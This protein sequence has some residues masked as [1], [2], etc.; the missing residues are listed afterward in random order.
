MKALIISDS[1]Y[2]TEEYLKLKTAI[3]S[4][5]EKKDFEMKEIKVREKDITYCTGCFGCWIKK[6]GECVIKDGM[7]EV[8]RNF[9]NSDTVIYLTPI[10]FGQFSAN[11]KNTLDRWLPNVLPFFKKRKDG[12]T[13]HPPRY[14][15]NP[16]QIIIGYAKE[17]SSED[18]NLFYDITKKHKSQVNVVVYREKD[19]DLF[20]VLNRW[21]LQRVATSL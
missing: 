17:L 11:I 15:E 9:N 2:Q 20:E 7:E 12:S 21:N 4:Y 13:M 5:L 10:V 6:P 8:N 1:E 14:P 3:H 16:A 18:E 19:E